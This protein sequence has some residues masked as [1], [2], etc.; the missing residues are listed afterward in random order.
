MLSQFPYQ[1]IYL[2]GPT[3][4]G[5]TTIARALQNKLSEPFLVIGIDQI[6]YMMRDQLN[7]WHTNTQAPGF[8][9]IP[10]KGADGSTLYKLHVGP[11]GQRMC[12]AFKDIVVTLA[13]SGHYIIVDDVSFGKEQ[14][15]EWRKALAPFKVLW[16]GITAPIDVLEK[17]ERER[18][19]RK[20]GSTRWQAEHVHEGVEYDFMINTAEKSLDEVV[21]LITHSN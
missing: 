4:S 8:S 21:A 20:I 9:W 15:D 13:K 5:K 14:V 11:F 3:S 12:Q 19:D 6:L 18:G 1:I 10:V 16:I 2:N 17:R 7:D